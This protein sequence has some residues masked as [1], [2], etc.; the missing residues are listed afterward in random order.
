MPIFI[1]IRWLEQ[2]LWRFE[3]SIFSKIVENSSNRHYR[4]AER[5]TIFLIA[6][7]YC[8][9]QL[10]SEIRRVETKLWAFEIYIWANLGSIYRKLIKIITKSSRKP[11]NIKLYPKIMLHANFH[12]NPSTR[13]KS[14]EGLKFRHFR[15]LPKPTYWVFLRDFL[16]DSLREFP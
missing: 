3:F 1:E 10:F 5:H 9:M 13:K 4:N 16:R 2:K 15:V 14:S 8:C 11:D 7:K 6:Q 12:L